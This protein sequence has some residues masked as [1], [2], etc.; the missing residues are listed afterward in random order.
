[1]K[2][3]GK[4]KISGKENIP[5]EAQKWLKNWMGHVSSLKVTFSD[6]TDVRKQFPKSLSKIGADETYQFSI[7]KTSWIL[8]V[9]ILFLQRVILVLDVWEK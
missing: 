1:M 5:P 3:V 6:E 2:L 4:K 7:T 9:K 8:E